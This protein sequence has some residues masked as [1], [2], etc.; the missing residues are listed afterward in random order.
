[1]SGSSIHGSRRTGRLFQWG[2]WIR[3]SSISFNNMS[4]VA[5]CSSGWIIQFR[6]GMLLLWV[7]LCPLRLVIFLAYQFRALLCCW[8]FVTDFGLA[9][10]IFAGWLLVVTYGTYEVV[11]CLKVGKVWNLTFLVIALVN[12]RVSNYGI[13][14]LLLGGVNVLSIVIGFVE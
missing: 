1:M 6:F 3:G 12:C 8:S 7:S 5:A 2:D 11:F 13:A 9:C 10:I 14:K 4:L